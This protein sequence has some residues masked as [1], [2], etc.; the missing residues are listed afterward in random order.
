MAVD[1]SMAVANWM[2]DP[3]ELDMF[4][5]H[6]APKDTTSDEWAIFLET[7]RIYRLSPM[8]KQIYLIGRW[9]SEK[10]RMVNTPQISIGGLRGKALE[11]NEFEGTTEP[12][13]GDENGNWYKLWPKKLG[14]YPYAARIGV[15]RRGFRA[16]K[17]GVAYWD[18][19]AQYTGK[20]DKR[21]LTHFWEDM[22]P[23]M[24]IKCAEA[25]AL[26]GAFEEVCGGLYIH[27]EMQQADGDNVVT[28]IP[29]V[30]QSDP[31]TDEVLKETAKNAR[32][33]GG[34][35]PTP[36]PKQQAQRPAPVPPQTPAQTETNKE[37]TPL[38]KIPVKSAIK[39]DVENGG[40]A[41]PGGGVLKWVDFVELAFSKQLN[42]KQFTLDQLLNAEW[43]PKYCEH[44]A[45]FLAALK[46]A[47]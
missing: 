13:W 10:K 20:D 21:R 19:L 26:R 14:K 3:Q 30:D 18:G 27:E 37:P 43:N 11:T 36:A 2:P 17:W 31:E 8:R 9:N 22:G 4:K 44:A 29:V 6:F 35:A 5:K 15:Y 46:K 41:A 28:V 7:C 25:D 38:N 23:H 12:E 42:A 45:A 39:K 33:N 16:P 1:Q 47:A 24:L 34:V 40:Y 32:S